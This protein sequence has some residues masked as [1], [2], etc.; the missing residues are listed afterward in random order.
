MGI[1]TFLKQVA[2]QEDDLDLLAFASK[3]EMQVESMIRSNEA[4]EEALRSL[5]KCST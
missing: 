5:S 2:Y 4:P 3:A 1:A